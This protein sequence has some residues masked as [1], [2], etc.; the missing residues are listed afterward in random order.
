M[1]AEGALGLTATWAC[2][3]LIAGTGASLPLGVY[4]T[5]ADGTRTPAKDHPLYRVLHDSPN[6]DQTALDFWEFMLAAVELRGNAYA[7][8]IRGVNGAVIGL[9]PIMAEPMRVRRAQDGDLEYEW[10]DGGRRY[11]AEQ[12]DIFHIRGFGG[13]PL[14]G[15]S[16]L[17]VCRA[18]FTSAHVVER[19]ASTTFANG[20]RPSGILS[21]DAQLTKEQRDEAERLLQAKFSG[22]VNAGRPMLL[23]KAMTWQQLTIDPEDAQMLESRKFSGEE[24]CRIFGVPPAMVGYGDKASNWGTGK[25]VDVMGFQ[26]FTLRRRLK[27]V[28]Q[29]AEKQLLSPADRAAGVTI[30]FN[31]EG[32]LRAD[33][34]ARASF[35][36]SG[37]QNGWAT[38]N[39]VRALENLPP[40]EGGWIPRMQSQN[41]PIT[42][43][44]APAALPSPAP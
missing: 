2:I 23:D 36:Q 30:E 13:G 41:V 12:Q 6:A 42:Q 28:E 18:A 27:R 44:P 43:A 8:I 33:S 40:V 21:T 20:V 38:I 1:G 5:A 19:A 24:I 26:K 4:R 37:L 22:A 15:A 14:G 10:H 3:N 34:A 16:T 9:L 7:E 31:L 35:Y 39:E 25:E 29:A 32:L 11:R 17:S